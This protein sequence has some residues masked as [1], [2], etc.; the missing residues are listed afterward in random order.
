[1]S[2]S[3]VRALV[4]LAVVQAKAEGKYVVI[5]AKVATNTNGRQRVGGI[6]QGPVR[7]A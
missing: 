6:K 4:A 7:W 5:P 2:K 1:M 3:Q